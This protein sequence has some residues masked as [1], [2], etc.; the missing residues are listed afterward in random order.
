MGN[1]RGDLPFGPPVY[2]GFSKIQ[3][4]QGPINGISITQCGTVY[5][6]AI[7]KF[8]GSAPAAPRAEFLADGIQ[9]P[10]ACRNF[11]CLRKRSYGG[12]HG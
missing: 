3:F 10:H 1:R 9:Q 6:F 5:L 7:E 11:E 4:V 8:Q 12:K 2:F